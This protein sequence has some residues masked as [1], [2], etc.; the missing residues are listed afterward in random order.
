MCY[1]GHFRAYEYQKN[2][3]LCVLTPLRLD[4]RWILLFVGPVVFEFVVCRGHG[5]EEKGKSRGCKEVREEASVR[6]P[7]WDPPGNK[8]R[9]PWPP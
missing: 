1:I 5:K 7:L 4:A 2:V 6:R 9:I 8:C 3:E